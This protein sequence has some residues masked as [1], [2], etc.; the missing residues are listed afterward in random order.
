MCTI[1]KVQS[2]INSNML[3]FTKRQ[4]NNTFTVNDEEMEEIMFH[5]DHL[6]RYGADIPK[7]I[8]K[9]LT[10]LDEDFILEL[11]EY[12][13]RYLYIKIGRVNCKFEQLIK[14]VKNGSYF[15]KILYYVN[16]NFKSIEV[17]IIK[18]EYQRIYLMQ[19]E[20]E[21]NYKI[22]VVKDSNKKFKNI[23]RYLFS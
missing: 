13:R 10:V 21:L 16:H 12:Q 3:S 2:E 1:N 5:L 14:N 11:L 23:L 4:L 15:N 20:S 9:M 19:K 17:E 18:L 7:V 22:Q 6:N 8:D